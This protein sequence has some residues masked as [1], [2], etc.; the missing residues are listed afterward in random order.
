MPDSQPPGPLDEAIHAALARSA[1]MPPLGF[2]FDFDGVLA[3]IQ[4]EPGSARPIAG[5]TAQLEQLA[6]LVEKVA[7]VS[8]RPVEFLAGHFAGSS[9][10]SLFGLYGLETL[11]DGTVERHHA[12]GSWEPV[13]REVTTAASR[14]LPDDVLVE[15]KPMSVALHYRKQPRH[16]RAVEDWAKAR[17]EQYGLAQQHGRM[18]VEL[19]PPTSIDKGT[20][21]A[22]EVTDL[23]CAWYFGDDISDVKGFAA[24][25]EQQA[26][27]PDFRG[28]CVAVENTGIVAELEQQADFVL[29]SP[30]KIQDLLRHAIALLSAGQP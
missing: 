1:A 18:V 2:F 16:R 14:E 8:A 20:V 12:A 26:E 17:A 23:R 11:I 6:T 19:K 28:V 22:G 15:E 21:L 7:I 10:I 27:N 13:I 9:R 3:P 30:L 5:L 25:H 24:L 4:D 29:A